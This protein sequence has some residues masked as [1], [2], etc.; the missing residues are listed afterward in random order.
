M[1]CE[2]EI[3]L[4]QLSGKVTALELAVKVF[5]ATHPDREELARVWRT[6]LPGQIDQFMD[7]PSYA[8]PAQRDALNNMLAQLSELIEMKLD[9]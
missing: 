5:I 8:V 3:P 2:L 7:Q 9:S 4:R 6:L 1:A